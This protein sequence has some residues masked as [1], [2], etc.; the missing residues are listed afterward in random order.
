MGVNYGQRRQR[1][2]DLKNPTDIVEYTI[3]VKNFKMSHYD[4]QLVHDII[5]ERLDVQEEKLKEK[6][7]FFVR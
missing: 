4:E 6:T 5:N 1:L 3:G 7:L 2:A